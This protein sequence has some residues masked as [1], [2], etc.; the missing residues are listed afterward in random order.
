[1]RNE[2]VPEQIW[3]LFTSSALAIERKEYQRA[4]VDIQ[5]ARASSAAC[6]RN[7]GARPFDLRVC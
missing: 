2:D 1:V 4:L 7:R 3:L 6:P 5:S